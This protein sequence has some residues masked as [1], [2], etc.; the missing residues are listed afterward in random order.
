MNGIRPPA[1]HNRE[2]A[3]AR[4]PRRLEKRRFVSRLVIFAIFAA[5]RL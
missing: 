3:K 1:F 4:R 5:S 2:D